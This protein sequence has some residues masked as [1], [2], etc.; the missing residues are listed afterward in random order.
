MSETIVSCWICLEQKKLTKEH[1]FKKNQIRSVYGKQV[2]FVG[3]SDEIIAGKKPRRAQGPNS[4]AF[5]FSAPICERCNGSRT[6]Q[7]D[8]AF[9]HFITVLNRGYHF[10]NLEQYFEV[11]PTTEILKKSGSLDLCRYLAK[12]LGNHAADANYPISKYLKMFILGE[13]DE[14]RIR[15]DCTDSNL[16]PEFHGQSGFLEHGGLIAAL[17]KDSMLPNAYLTSLNV[18]VFH[19][20]IRFEFTDEERS[21]LFVSN[22]E[23]LRRVRMGVE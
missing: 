3:N 14:D 11:E 12:I 16:I 9:D 6:Q 10:Q 21:D 17:D 5:K 18:G 15:F 2:L 1:K 13:T 8:R 4:E 23:L 20:Q 7:A 19:F 22:P